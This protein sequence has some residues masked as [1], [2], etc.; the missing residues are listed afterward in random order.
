MQLMSIGRFS[1]L[2]GLGVKALRHYD[3][4][5]L[6][7]PEAVDDETGYRFY[8][9]DQVAAAEAIRRLRRL[10]L[11][12]D[13][14]RAVL[15]AG[16]GGA[17]RDVLVGHQR[18]LAMR[19]VET[20]A[21]LTELQSLIDGKETVMGARS[22]SLDPEAHRRLGVDLFNRCWTWMEKPAR[23]QDED[24]E[25][26]HCAHASAYHWRQVGTR[27]NFARSEWQCSRVY[28]V[29]GLAEPSLRHARRCLELVEA[30]PAEMADWDLSG[31]YE[32]LARAHAIAGD[33][34]EA[35][36]YRAL[37]IEALARIG[38]PEDRAP[39]EADLATIRI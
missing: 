24:D 9:P 36:R 27:A 7:V 39:I 17:I 21:A 25:M 32:A 15:E 3:E 33:G 8:G 22:E 10:D 4:I 38:Q 5:G 13:E 30:A 19:R 14:I 16:D 35:E 20:R 6:L 23:T 29:L 31:A 26:L 11:P 37:G 2:T 34:D 28:A 18:R 12:L 1:R